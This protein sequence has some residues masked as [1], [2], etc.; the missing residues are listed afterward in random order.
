M[1]EVTFTADEIDAGIAEL[2]PGAHA[3]AI[4]G[5]LIQVMLRRRWDRG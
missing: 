2:F 3:W 5:T 4:S 1:D